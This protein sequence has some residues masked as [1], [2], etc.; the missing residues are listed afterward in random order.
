MKNQRVVTLVKYILFK[1]VGQTV[2]LRTKNFTILVHRFTQGNFK[3]SI[4]SAVGAFFSSLWPG[5]TCKFFGQ[6]K[7]NIQLYSDGTNYYEPRMLCNSNGVWN[8]LQMEVAIIK[9]EP[10]K[11]LLVQNLAINKLVNLMYHSN[12]KSTVSVIGSFD[13][14]LF[15]KSSA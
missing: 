13:K 2:C 14:I 6:R 3:N 15:L 8:N 11:M 12:K 1:L 7:V 10:K 4:R 5:V 9:S